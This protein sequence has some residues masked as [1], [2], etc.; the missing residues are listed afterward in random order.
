[1]K[2]QIKPYAH[3]GNLNKQKRYTSTASINNNF[4]E[5]IQLIFFFKKKLFSNVNMFVYTFLIFSNKKINKILINNIGKVK[6][7][8]IAK[9]IVVPQ[10]TLSKN[11]SS[12]FLYMCS[13]PEYRGADWIF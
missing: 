4:L 7:D 13:L 6:T 1:M 5:N 12:L 10:I 9:F 8:I 2:L 3:T 11:I